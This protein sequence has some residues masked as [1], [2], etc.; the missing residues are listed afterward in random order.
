MLWALLVFGIALSAMVIY[1][2][3][4]QLAGWARAFSAPFAAVEVAVSA[5]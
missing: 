2:F 3:A 5:G 4:S 1:T